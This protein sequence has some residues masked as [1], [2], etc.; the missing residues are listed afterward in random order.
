MSEFDWKTKQEAIDLIIKRD[1]KNCFICKG[2][3]GKK[4]KITIDH[5]IPTSKG[6]TWKLS[7]LRI[8]HK[9]CNIWKGD[10][11]PLSDGTIP[12]KPPVR[13]KKSKLVKRS[14]PTICNACHSGRAL[15][16]GQ[17]CDRCHSGPQPI[18]FPT[19]YKRPTK[20]CDHR[21]F[22]CFACILGFA[23]RAS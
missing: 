10:R 13:V 1:G 7:N 11:I 20:D 17:V 3:F 16:S 21:I 19:W 23:E 2:P 14:R 12:E 4:E 6:G 18:D 22:H 9:H 5:W 8:A 15:M